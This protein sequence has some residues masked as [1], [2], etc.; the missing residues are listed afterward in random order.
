MQR[1]RIA[2]SAPERV[3]RC[4]LVLP[5]VTVACDATAYLSTSPFRRATTNVRT[6]NE[7]TLHDQDRHPAAESGL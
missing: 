2:M 4:A 7:G 1:R 6:R 3:H 5:I